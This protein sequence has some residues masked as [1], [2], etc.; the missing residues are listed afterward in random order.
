MGLIIFEI[1]VLVGGDEH[2]LLNRESQDKWLAR[3]EDGEFDIVVL[4]PLCGS[5]SRASWANDDG[6]KPCRDRAQPW[7]F[8]C[9]E[10][11]QQERAESGNEFIHFSIGAIRRAQQ[12]RTKGF[13][14][15]AVLEHPEDLG[16][17]VK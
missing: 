14:V 2:D 11:H 9:Q 1:D 16:R 3:V 17:M 15:R 7:G 6:P 13:V 8:L 10:A 12:A 5:W 4:Y